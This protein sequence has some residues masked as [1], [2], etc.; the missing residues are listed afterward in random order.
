MISDY[1]NSSDKLW[2]LQNGLSTEHGF[3]TGYRRD[4]DH[5]PNLFYNQKAS[6][7]HGTAVIRITLQTDFLQ[8][9]TSFQHGTAVIRITLQTGFLQQKTSF[10]HGTA[11][12]RITLKTGFYNKKRVLNMVPP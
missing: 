12:I 11:V 1:R 10:E 8:Q 2:D 7:Q 9:K 4:P 5:A 3:L 6:F